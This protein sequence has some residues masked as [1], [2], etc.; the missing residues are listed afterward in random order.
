[1]DRSCRCESA[2]QS[3][4]EEGRYH[5]ETQHVHSH[6]GGIVRVEY[7]RWFELQIE[8]DFVDTFDL[9]FEH[10]SELKCDCS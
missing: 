10:K 6:L 4:R 1:M 3:L 5:P 7:E 9:N 2:D 8:P